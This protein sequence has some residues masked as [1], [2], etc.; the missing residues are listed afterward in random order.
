MQ[1]IKYLKFLFLI[2]IIGS[3]RNHDRIIL[4]PNLSSEV[5]STYRTTRE[6]INRD[7]IKDAFAYNG[8]AL[9]KRKTFSRDSELITQEEI[10]DVILFKDQSKIVLRFLSGYGSTIDYTLK[11]SNYRLQIHYWH[12]QGDYGKKGINVG[13]AKSYL[14]LNS[15]S[16]QLGDTILGHINLVTK[17]YQKGNDRYFDIYE[18]YFTS[19][20]FPKDSV[21]KYPILTIE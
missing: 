1:R 15:E 21:R 13:H 7:S 4:T 10:R 14:K 6:W 8:E 9:I 19:I 3:C 12:P 11:K 2:F 5:H 20:V 16:I 18:G 17:P